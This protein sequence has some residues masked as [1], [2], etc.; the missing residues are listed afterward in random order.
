MGRRSGWLVARW[1]LR[2]PV[3]G[4]LAVSGSAAGTM[5]VAPAQAPAR[6]PSALD[7][8]V[9]AEARADARERPAGPLLDDDR[10]RPLPA[11]DRDAAT[12][13]LAQILADA[14]AP[15]IAP[16]DGNDGEA[17]ARR[18]DALSLYSAGREKLLAGDP[19]GA[20]ADL[21][22][23]TRLDPSA[24]EPWRELGEVQALLGRR[25]PA[26]ASFTQAVRRGLGDARALHW[27]GREARRAGN[28]ADAVAYLARARAVAT[29]QD[30]ALPHLIDAELAEALASRGNLAAARECLARA[31]D[32]PE[33]FA[34]S[35]RLRA[36]LAELYRRRAELWARAGDWSCRLGLYAEADEA[37]AR[38]MR[39]PSID[40]GAVL[41][42]RVGALLAGARPAHAA[43][44]LVDEV[45]A[46]HGVPDDRVLALLAVVGAERS[47]RAPVLEALDVLATRHGAAPPGGAVD[48]GLA[49]ARATQ[50]SPTEARQVLGAAL[51]RA[52]RDPGL[53]RAL[54]G[55]VPPDDAEAR[56]ALV[57]AAD[58]AAAAALAEAIVLDGRAVRAQVER[59][60]RSKELDTGVLT[61][62]AILARLGRGAEAME[63]LERPAP[64]G[65]ATLAAEGLA[66][67]S[68][69]L[70]SMG[71]RADAERGL[72]GLGER[73]R[74]RARV[75]RAL[76]RHA[77]AAKAI[78]DLESPTPADLLDAAECA[79][80]A[81]DAERAES[82]L[83]RAA[84][85]DPHD[86]GVREA[87]VA[88]YLPSGPLADSRRLADAVR[89]LRE[90]AQAAIAVRRSLARDLVESRLWGPAADALLELLA[91]NPSQ[92]ELVDLL[93]RVGE[94]A[95]KTDPEAARRADA[96]LDQRA[97]NHP[98]APH[99]VSALARVLAGT[100]RAEQAEALL[101]RRLEAWPVPE[102][103]RLREGILRDKLGRGDEADAL[104]LARLSPS[105][106][107]VEASIELASLYLRRGDV[108]AAAGALADGL[109]KGVAL[110]GA[111]KS[112]LATLLGRL[113]AGD[114][115]ALPVEQARAA[116]LVLDRAAEQGVALT[117]KLQVKRLRLAIATSPDDPGRLL[118]VASDVG[119]SVPEVGDSAV[120]AVANALAKTSVPARAARFLRVV[121]LG[122]K[123]E[124]DA[125][126]IAW[127]EAVVRLGEV[128]DA[129]DLVRDLPD[130]KRAL[131]VG[132]RAADPAEGAPTPE[133]A[134]A[135]TAY[136]LSG[137]MT[138]FD[139][140]P[141]AVA[142]LK[143]TLLLEPGHV[144][145]SNDL[146]YHY[147]DKGVNLD[148][149]RA[150]LEDAY[151]KDPGNGNLIDSLGW[152]R[153]KL[154]RLEDWEEGGTK[155]E[156]AMTLLRRASEHEEGSQNPV[157]LD[158]LGD[159][160]WR[161]GRREDAKRTWTIGDAA[162]Q[163]FV[164]T[165]ENSDAPPGT[166]RLYR[167]VRDAIAAKIRAVREGAEPPLAPLGARE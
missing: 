2:T 75:L 8:L 82:H 44:L 163:T 145:A 46:R 39:A 107:G 7:R 151:A 166:R 88:L 92:A 72:E 149:A 78:E 115:E 152:L 12:R 33:P 17:P 22:A 148:E 59:L 164:E 53:A 159:A 23:S 162:A 95:A 131:L 155:R 27:L 79:V 103:S 9:Q 43:R 118:E 119:R 167:E 100:G 80:L 69:L 96:W 123:G 136:E 161:A 71:R 55:T 105:P 147:A 3:A 114:D 86:P 112:L 138:A 1:S 106:R 122:A 21:E 120:Q 41:T 157:V 117:P 133:R 83:R 84:T 91:S 153:Y 132:M 40:P 110:S 4:A 76:Y 139:R 124:S 98:D 37:Y 29:D 20:L 130:A 14:P 51:A 137:H 34:R 56:L 18:A 67:R 5:I 90:N 38:A 19:A 126:M 85:I 47:L 150:L 108:T 30:A 144:L 61:A 143:L 125:P 146:G 89:D 65:Q 113:P 116:A 70:A 58:P 36:E 13:P 154:G 63:L 10:T 109:P 52:P 64:A 140:E 129:E 97:T 73:P 156:G 26:T 32:L 60:S 101:A 57:R 49:V 81:G 111:Q 121:A 94:G 42:R 141:E 134:R 62:A 25:G 128:R 160:L 165:V 104:A 68:E 45:D 6:E 66:L 102:L 24:A 50:L 135:A 87:L 93:A 35:T 16:I 15:P 158:H 77:D 142:M 74:A 28:A 127:I 31:L 11:A 99:A 54:L 48:R